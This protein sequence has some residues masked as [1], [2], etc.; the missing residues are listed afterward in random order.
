MAHYKISYIHELYDI[1]LNYAKKLAIIKC[2]AQTQS[3]RFIMQMQAGDKLNASAVR[4][5]IHSATH[6]HPALCFRV[7]V[8]DRSLQA[9]I[10]SLLPFFIS[11]VLFASER[12]ATSV[13]R[14][15]CGDRGTHYI[16][17]ERN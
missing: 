17:K 11:C 12:G 3:M 5:D 1:I 10:T 13:L 14:V 7:H 16:T 15:E 2:F 8:A 6:S 9:L 4:D